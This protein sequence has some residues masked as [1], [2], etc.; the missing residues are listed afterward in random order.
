M[1][2]IKYFLCIALVVALLMS[3]AVIAAAADIADYDSARTTSISLTLSDD[4]DVVRGAQVSVYRVADLM[5]D[6]NGYSYSYLENYT[7]CGLVID[8]PQDR[9]LAEAMFSYVCDNNITATIARYTDVN[10]Y[11]YFGD[12][13]QG[14]YLIAQTSDVEGF[15]TFSPFLTYL[16]ITDENGWVYD[17]NATPKVDIKSETPPPPP[18]PPPPSETTVTTTTPEVTTPPVTTPPFIFTTPPTTTVT[19]EETEETTEETEET[20]EETE[21]ETTE[22]EEVSEPTRPSEPIVTTTRDPHDDDANAGQWGEHNPHD[23]DANA[24]QWGE[25]LAQTG[26]LNW[27]IPILAGMGTAFIAIGFI[28]R[29][30][31]RKREG[32]GDK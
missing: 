25:H 5:I 23:D 30:T 29:N 16:P 14:L 27:P 13:E 3:M 31:G 6:E 26:Q 22:T 28:I 32:D 1:K 10:G 17:V 19:T 11:V 18:P 9:D 12:L 21:E 7:D 4:K 24:G 15:T 20:E 8:D 2:T